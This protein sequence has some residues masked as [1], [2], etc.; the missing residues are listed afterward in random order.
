MVAASEK[1]I[2]AVWMAVGSHTA[3]ALGSHQNQALCAKT[4]GLESLCF[5]TRGLKAAESAHILVS[6]RQTNCTLCG[7]ETFWKETL[8]VLNL[9]CSEFSS[10]VTCATF[11]PFSTGCQHRA[12][13]QR[14]PAVSWGCLGRCCWLRLL[15]SSGGAGAVLPLLSSLTRLD[16]AGACHTKE[17]SWGAVGPLLRKVHGH[18]PTPLTQQSVKVNG[19]CKRLKTFQVEEE[20]K[21]KRHFIRKH[22]Q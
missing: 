2:H 8:V 4:M 6:P 9:H 7:T 14:C 21:F 20:L 13:L 1:P 3:M 18:G 10:Q 5:P 16:R 19:A 11:P 12:V 15:C 22:H 17:R